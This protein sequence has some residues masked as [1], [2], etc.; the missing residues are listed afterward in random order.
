[1]ASDSGQALIG[2][3]IM[4]LSTNLLSAFSGIIPDRMRDHEVPE[5]IRYVLLLSFAWV[6][7]L[8]SWIDCTSRI[9]EIACTNSLVGGLIAANVRLAYINFN[10]R[11]RS[12]Q[13]LQSKLSYVVWPAYLGMLIGFW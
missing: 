6:F 11:G 12:I 2:L 5:Q 8:V 10:S 1:M 7:G 9:S 4:C 3:G 13:N